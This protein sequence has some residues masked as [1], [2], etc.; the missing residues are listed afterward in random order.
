MAKYG[1]V[2]NE[3]IQLKRRDGT[4][5]IGSISTVAVKDRRGNVM[6]Y[7]GI[8]EDITR[9][10]R[11]EGQLIESQKAE[12]I[13]RLTGGIAHEFNNMLTSI[14]GYSELTQMDLE[15][16]N[17]VDE[18][19]D[20]ILRTAEHAQELISQLM[21]FS[22]KAITEP[23]IIN[24]NRVLTGFQTLIQKL[25][26]EDLIMN[27]IPGEDLGNV[28]ADPR[29]IEQVIINL[30]T[31][32]RDAMSFTTK[33]SRGTGLGLSSVY[34]IIKQSNGFINIDSE[35]G[36][37]TVV[38]IYLPRVEKPVGTTEEKPKT[39]ALPS[40]TEIILVV[41]DEEKVR[42]I[43][44]KILS[45]CGYNIFMAR[46]G[47]EALGLWQENK[48]RVDLL[49]TDIVL[50][51]ISG[52]QL[53]QKLLASKPDLKVIYMSGYSD[54]VI[55]QY[56]TLDKEVSF[57]HKPFTSGKLAGKIREVLD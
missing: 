49:L 11:L 26:G 44:V 13:D 6:C 33:K 27:F 25:I 20:G 45:G 57:I 50:P 8:I 28:E 3:D 32:S 37:G 29:Q 34:G 1:F 36:R 52:L 41:E 12:A 53:S 30:V 4:P 40:G 38:S 15:S 55:S 7:D 23:K 14:I 10:K 39:A 19:L 2:R 47:E 17:P 31:N 48:D 42:E 51:G 18:Y 43:V 24:L 22:R 21:T 54:E 16:G 56:G 9:R 46:D 35:P 5:F